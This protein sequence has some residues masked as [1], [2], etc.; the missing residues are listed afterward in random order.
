MFH[1]CFAVIPNGWNFI[2]VN[3]QK[4]TTL[5]S[6][7]YGIAGYGT[8]PITDAEKASFPQLQ[9]TSE[10][11]DVRT[12]FIST[13]LTEFPTGGLPFS[14]TTE[15]TLWASCFQSMKQLTKIGS[16][17]TQ[18]ATNMD[19][20]FKDCEVLAAI[21][22]MATGNVKS[23]GETFLRCKAITEFPSIDTSSCT[24]FNSTWLECEDMV[25]FP[26]IDT[27]SGPTDIGA[28]ISFFRTWR[29][30]VSF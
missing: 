10:L 24:N 26:L 4:V 12:C 11:T 30:C 14:N 21:P 16:I 29:D 19:Q 1:T 7:F 18:S 2:P 5:R 6:A 20:T 3:M 9:T 23:F 8:N 27:V 13:Q 28:N 25:K 15:V 17:D 22:F